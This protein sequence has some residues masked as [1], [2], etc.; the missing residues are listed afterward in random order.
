MIRQEP[1]ISIINERSFTSSTVTGME[2]DILSISFTPTSFGPPAPHFVRW[3]DERRSVNDRQ[4][5][6]FPGPPLNLTITPH[7]TFH[8][9]ERKD[10]EVWR[11]NGWDTRGE[12]GKVE[13][14][15]R[16]PR[17]PNEWREEWKAEPMMNDRSRFHVTSVCL[18][19]NPVNR[20]WTIMKE[21]AP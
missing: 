11:W 4:T 5:S 2:A 7:L 12:N 8:L 14:V 16:I 13:D 6:S 17:K 15:E 3:E 18:S 21:T 20:K 9:T 1:A 19:V 10:E